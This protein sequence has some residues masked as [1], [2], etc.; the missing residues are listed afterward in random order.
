MDKRKV[1]QEDKK[2]DENA[3]GLTSK[4]WQRQTNGSRKEGGRGLTIYI[5]KSK[6]KLITAD[7]NSTDNTRTNRRATKT[8]KQE[9]IQLYGY[10]KWRTSKISWE[11]LDMATKRK[12]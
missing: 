3:Q 1:K 10:F 6:E 9:E 5:K 8:S 12:P 4:R 11:D 2:V 7:S